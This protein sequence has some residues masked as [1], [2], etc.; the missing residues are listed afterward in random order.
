MSNQMARIEKLEVDKRGYRIPWFVAW[1]DGEPDFRVIGPGKIGRAVSENRCWV[2]G[3]FLGAYR[4]YVIGPM[5]AVNR[6]SAEPPCHRDCA[7]YAA[8][9][10]PFL[11]KPHM[12]RVDATLPKD[13][14]APAGISIKRNPGV[15]SVWVT[16]KLRTFRDPNGD[17]L[18]NVGEP[19]ETL[20]F[21]EGREA[22]RAEVDASIES[23]LPLLRE[24]AEK[25]R[26]P[27]KSLALL[28]RM[29]EDARQ[30]LP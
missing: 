26:F 3:D 10:C 22:T 15:C 13:A 18:F 24:Q 25:D 28:E 9:H 2:C 20:W 11:T 27:D 12:H 23:G 4:A 5:C 1:I 21:A 30:Y 19:E 8:T 29:T 17:I 7:I 14:V 6:T 16:K